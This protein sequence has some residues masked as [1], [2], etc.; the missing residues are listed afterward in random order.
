MRDVP[1]AIVQD[2]RQIDDVE[3]SVDD[4]ANVLEEVLRVGEV[5]V[6]V[7]DIASGAR[8]DLLQP[9]RPRDSVQ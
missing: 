6:H 7:D 9:L 2:E 4:I 8:G 1:H 5:V 3:S